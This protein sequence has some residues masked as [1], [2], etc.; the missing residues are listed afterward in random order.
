MS[1]TYGVFIKHNDTYVRSESLEKSLDNIITD[2]FVKDIL[3]RIPK[4]TLEELVFLDD[5]GVY[6]TDNE[7]VFVGKNTKYKYSETNLD[8]LLFDTLVIEQNPI[9]ATSAVYT[10]SY[11][12]RELGSMKM[13]LDGSTSKIKVSS[14]YHVVAQ[15]GVVQAVYTKKSKTV[16][17]Y[18]DLPFKPV[19]VDTGL[20]D[21]HLYFRFP[22]GS[23]VTLSN[24]P[25]VKY[26]LT[27]KHI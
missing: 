8:A 26:G 22:D 2:I 19:N 15:E 21:F 20:G 14:Q 4:N 10:I 5:D 3:P 9:S 1:S 7:F 27:K 13:R 17:T 16:R 12:N 11:T 24:D 6:F 23:E 25:T 18:Q